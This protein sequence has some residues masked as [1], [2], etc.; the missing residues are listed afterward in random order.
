MI[1]ASLLRIGDRLAK[2]LIPEPLA[3][4]PVWVTLETG[5]EVCCDS[6][7]TLAVFSELFVDQTYR[8]ALEQLSSV[9]SVVDL[10]ANRGLFMLYVEHWLRLAGRKD[11]PRYV[12]VEPS[13]E[14]IESL[15]RHAKRNSI[16]DRLTVGRGVVSDK[17]SGSAEIFYA[18]HSNTSGGIVPDKRLTTRSVPILDLAKLTSNEPIDLLKI[19]IEGAEQ[20]FLGEYKDVLGRAKTVVIELH[21]HYVDADAC[22]KMIETSGL[23]FVEKTSARHAQM[24]TEIYRRG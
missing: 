6:E 9:G 8:P 13:S 2:R 11:R 20:G 21:H 23:R 3:L 14:N 10:G 15:E 4:R 24:V 1:P 12:A 18:S 19:D 22:R 5:I 7:Q 16:S 17:R